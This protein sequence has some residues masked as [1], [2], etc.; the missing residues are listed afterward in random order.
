MSGAPRVIGLDLSLTATGIAASDGTTWTCSTSPKQWIGDRLH[1]ITVAVFHAVHGAGIGEIVVAIED[2]PANAQSAG[3]TGR[4]HGAVLLDLTRI[5]MEDQLGIVPRVALVPPASLKKYA[6]GKG[7]ATKADMRV[8]L[9]QRTGIDERD[10]NRVDAAWLRFMA[11]DAY[12]HP[13][14]QLPQSHRAA[15]SKIKWPALV[16]YDLGEN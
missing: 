4:V 16:G 2:M 8:A 14:F 11:L 7:N 15:L 5:R 1:D 12:G 3:I 6:T 10:D 13:A 9:L